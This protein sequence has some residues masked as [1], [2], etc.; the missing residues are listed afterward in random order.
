MFGFRFAVLG[1][2]LLGREFSCDFISLKNRAGIPI[3][4]GGCSG[5]VDVLSIQ[6][7]R[8]VLID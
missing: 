8:N 5:C 4:H 7:L 3:I 2:N 6:L 1:A